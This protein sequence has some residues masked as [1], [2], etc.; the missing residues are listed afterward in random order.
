MSNDLIEIEIVGWTKFQH[1]NGKRTYDWLKLSS[2]IFDDAEI[3][4][5]TPSEFKVWV[6][7]LCTAARARSSAIRVSIKRG[8][9]AIGVQVKC[10]RNAISKLE[11]FQIVSVKSGTILVP[12]NRIE[13]STIEENRKEKNR[14]KE[15]PKAEQTTFA[16]SEIQKTPR[17]KSEPPESSI[18]W[19]TYQTEY[20]SRWKKEPPPR[21]ARINS[22]LKKLVS[23]FGME[24]ATDMVKH[25]FKMPDTYYLKNF[26]P[27]GLLISQAH[28]IYSSMTTGRTMSKGMMRSMESANT[29]QETFAAIDRGEV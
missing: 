2:N 9:S 20:L 27:V 10:V 22:N 3:Q 14:K 1:H 12:Q 8:A 7:C 5:L 19:A 28:Q 13:E 23:E 24:S 15:Y 17:S 29:L 18:L 11:S 21:N 16:D 6:W 26:H 4:T 25:Y